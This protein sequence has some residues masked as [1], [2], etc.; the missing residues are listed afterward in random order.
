[1]L[2][3]VGSGKT[4]T[5][6]RRV[7]AHLTIDEMPP[8]RVLAVT[9][10]NRAA[11]HIRAALAR[12]VGRQAAGQVHLGTFH[13]L[14]ADI[15]RSAAGHAG[16]P[17]DL[18]ILDEEDTDEILRELGAHTPHRVRFR[19]HGD[20][21]KVKPG[22]ATLAL[23]REG[24]FSR[25]RLAARYVAALDE[26]GAV[27]FAGLVLLTR[28]VLQEVPEVRAAWAARFDAVLVDEVQDTH[29]SEY[30]VLRVLAEGAR[31]RC[32]V[33]DLDQTI[34]G[35]RGSAPRALLQ[36]VADE[37]GPVTERRL[38]HSFRA[39]GRL[40]A[41]SDAVAAD[42]PDRTSRVRPG[43]GL[44]E[45]E[46]AQERA[47]ADEAAEHAGIAALC[48]DEIA[49]GVPPTDIALLA[50]TNREIQDLARAFAARG[51]PCT[52]AEEL[53]YTRRMEIKDALALA[54]LVV[55]RGDE[56]AARRVA[57]RLVRAAGP[58]VLRALR[59]EGRP[60]GLHVADLFDAGIVASGAPLA[61][62]SAPDVVVLDT[63]TTGLDPATDEV[64]EIAAIR[65]RDGVATGEVLHLLVQGAVPV[66]DAEAVHHISDAM[67]AERGVPAPE[68]L[69]QLQ[70]FVG[71][72]P[73]AGHNVGFDQTMLEAHGARVGVPLR[74]RIAWDTLPIARR[75]VAEPRHT[76]EHLVQALA[77]PVTPTHRALDDVEATIALAQA[78]RARAGEHAAA[79]S[80]L[81]QRHAPAFARI[82]AALD[83][84]A[85][86]EHR[87][88]AL[89]QAIVDEALG[90]MYRRDAG[91][92]AR[93]AAL[94]ARIG[95]LDPEALP[96]RA[97]VRVALD[98]A[99]LSREADALDGAGGVRLITVHQS[100]GLEFPHV[101]VPG[102][103]EG[104]LPGF[105][106]RDDEDELAEERRVFYVAVTRAKRRLTLTWHRASR[107]GRPRER[108]RFLEALEQH[109]Q[110]AP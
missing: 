65:T 8:Q 9:F 43:P 24:R 60:I 92:S 27:D 91:S 39:T 57:R 105:R 78:L 79:R 44:V 12:V 80:T 26:Q 85:A 35:W 72:T 47:Y 33:G 90:P 13:A 94:P 6:A 32:F 10:T 16:L 58:D 23:W 3:A 2:A 17:P 63:E 28:A 110:P 74:F 53:R 99:T 29:A 81:L 45:G 54:R 101:I 34:Y 67:R 104:V 107:D 97:A 31:S 109:L 41:L 21:A 25:S 46:P 49:A 30:A 14:C 42:M 98:R 100:K 76:L 22:A 108:S 52:T 36:R 4:T 103:V 88:G 96:A 71:D 87:P 15:L 51:V 83:R 75:L 62:L 77:L 61:G 106:A 93:L 18:R 37:L 5:L 50:R 19:L 20:A 84:W 95:A 86:A 59:V 69:R 48:A 66:G 56:A 68:A 55:D 70:A 82:R 40:V 11:G 73:I 38:T 102:L 64:V 89:L 7:E 1:V